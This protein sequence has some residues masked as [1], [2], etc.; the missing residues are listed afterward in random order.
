MEMIAIDD[1]APSNLV[2]PGQRSD[3]ETVVLSG[4]NFTT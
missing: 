1:S 2:V 3:Y 4:T